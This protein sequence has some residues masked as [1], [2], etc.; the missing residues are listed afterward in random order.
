M[1]AFSLLSWQKR[2]CA[3]LAYPIVQRPDRC[4][5]ILSR[6][7]R[8]LLENALHHTRANAELPADLEHPVTAR[9]QFENSRL[10][11]GLNATPA[12]LGPVCPGARETGIDPLSKNPPLKLSKYT[13]HLKHRLARA[14][15]RVESLLVKEQADSLVMEALENTEQVG[16]R[17]TEPIH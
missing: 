17:S 12:E 11:G 7:P 14:R 1:F 5:C 16:E 9:L 15:R 4:R 13:Q 8:L 3:A 10:D 6:W 2:T